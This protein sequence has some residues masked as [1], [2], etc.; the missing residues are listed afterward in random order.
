MLHYGDSQF[1]PELRWVPLIQLGT[2]AVLVFL[3]Y[4][5]YRSIKIGEQRSIWVG[6]AKETAHQLG[7]PISSLLGW[8]EL[9]K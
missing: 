9:L 6:M 5:G 1:V 4:L 7:T 8:V 3:G 2:V